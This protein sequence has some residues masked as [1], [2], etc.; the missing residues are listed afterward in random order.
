MKLICN[1]V[2]DE[3]GKCLCEDVI[4]RKACRHSEPHYQKENCF[5]GQCYG[6]KI[7]CVEYKLQV[8]G[9]DEVVEE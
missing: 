1:R 2:Y 7:M 3:N 4:K 8:K 6:Q 9:F 5:R